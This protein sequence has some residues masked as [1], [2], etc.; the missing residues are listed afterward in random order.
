MVGERRQRRDLA[1]SRAAG[2][3]A[4]PAK[5]TAAGTLPPVLTVVL[6]RHGHTTRSEPEQYLGQRIDIPISD[7][8]RDQALALRDRLTGVSVERVISSPLQRAF[9]TASLLRPD[10]TIERDDRLLEA[11]YGDWE[12]HTVDVIEARWPAERRAW[13][14]DP[15]RVGPPAGERGLDVAARASAFVADL[16]AWET[17]F[18][19]P[20]RNRTVLVVGHSTLNRILLAAVLGLELRDYRRRLRQDWLNL[21]V[22]RLSAADPD[23]ALLLLANDVAHLQHP[24]G[25]PWGSPS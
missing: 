1:A 6:T 15:A 24:S 25:V 12:G 19:T 7:R 5:E 9:Q 2:G 3:R 21:T 23:G 10:A 17:A 11:D 13:E 14:A 16:R 18:D 4:S 20:G 22:L 8:G